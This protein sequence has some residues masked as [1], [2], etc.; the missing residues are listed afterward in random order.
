ME[1][2][3]WST[4]IG[5][6]AFFF[7]GLKSARGGLQ[8]VAGNRMRT[9]LSRLTSNRFL[10]LVFGALVTVMLQSSGATSVML[11]SFVE[12][13]L[14][15]LSQAAAVLLGADIG[16]TATVFLLSIH[17]L[18]D[19]ALLIV[20]LGLLL[21]GMYS[22]RKTKHVGGILL[23]FG[24]IFYGMHL[25]TTAAIPLKENPIARELF[26]YLSGNA[27]HSL[28]L[29]TIIAGVLHSAGTIG[30][31]IALALAGTLTFE[32]TLPI[33]L[34]ANI[35]T[36]ITAVISGANSN[37]DGKRVAAVHTFSKVIATAIIFPFLPLAGQVINVVSIAVASVV[38]LFDPGVAG[39][40][41]LAHVI[42]NAIL[43]I[44][45]LPLLDIVVWAVRKILPEPQHKEEP[46]GP[47][48][49]SHA[50]LTTTPLAFAQVKLEILRLAGLVKDLVD[51]SLRMFSKGLDAAEEI[52]RIETEDDKIDIL[53]KAV[54]FYLAKLSSENLSEGDAK[55][56]MA[57]LSIAQDL[58]EIGDTI[59]KEMAALARKKMSRHG[60]FSQEGW[61]DLRQFQKLVC[62]NMELT[63]S[64][65]AHSSE[66]LIA[67][68]IRHES[69]MD[70]VEQSLRLQH[71]TRL[72]HALKESLDT[73]SIHLDIL[74]SFRRI[75]AKLTHVVKMAGEH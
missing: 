13:G 29:A 58:E 53:E 2:F 71:L 73:S 46:F 63:M 65:L 28:I 36:C 41:V 22:Q 27:L 9:V 44:F 56:Q 3:S 15:Q 39:R 16:T 50:A 26:S 57:L 45:F 52:E 37:I 20:A 69:H 1:T 12:T 70:G 21:Q 54:R 59:S 17:G 61:D 62:E 64:I 7:F 5:G 42:F 74:A 72:N 55:R 18:T 6:F 19:Y 14:I 51:G 75:N 4:L 32:A 48:Y 8:A 11:I 38:P 66:E 33:V 35:G 49:L 30:I 25:M 31:A 68:L 24:L 10:A 34:G 23:G 67:K 60:I 40:I 47:K 43:A